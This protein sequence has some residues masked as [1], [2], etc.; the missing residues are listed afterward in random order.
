MGDLHKPLN[1]QSQI[2]L[3][4]RPSFMISDILGDKAQQQREQQH[5]QQQH[6]QQLGIERS[7]SGKTD[8]FLTE[9]MGVGHFSRTPHP[10]HHVPAF[11]YA[12][13]HLL[14]SHHDVTR[15]VAGSPRS[16]GS[17]DTPSCSQSPAGEE[18]EESDIDVD[19][20]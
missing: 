5:Q 20:K 10:F 13:L 1:A 18:D 2:Q 8:F 6:Q 7:L 9:K 12:P 4:H 17:E 11:R 14:T 16:P 15:H 3:Q 19:S